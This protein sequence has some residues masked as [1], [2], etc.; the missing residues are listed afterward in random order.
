[1]KYLPI[2]AKLF[3]ENR[4]NF[5]KALPPHSIAFFTSNDEMPRSADGH[6]P[7]RQN[8]DLFYLSGIDQEQ[9]VLLLFPDAPIAAYKEVLFI[10]KTDETIAVW[11][12]HKYTIEEARK[13]SGIET[14]V[15]T[16]HF[17][18]ICDLV[19]HHAISVFLNLNEHD[20]FVT[21]IECRD[22]RFA[23]VLRK[24]HPLH[25][26][27]RAAP[28]MSKLRSIKSEPEIQLIATAIDI[29]KNAFN[30]LLTFIR[31][32]CT[33]Y[34]IEAEIIHEFISKRSSGHAYYPII[35][36]GANACILHY[37]QNNQ[38]CK[39]GDLILMDFGAEYAN[40]AAD[41]TRTVPVNGKFSPRQRQVYEAVLRVLK[42]ARSLLVVG[43]TMEAYNKAVGKIMELELIELGLLDAKA[44]EQHNKDPKALPLYKKY[45]NHG[46]SH[47]LGLDVHDVGNRYEPMQAG[48]V[49]T[50]EPGIY[51]PEENMGIRL[52]NDILITKDGPLDLTTDIPIEVDAIEQMM[53]QSHKK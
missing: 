5:K 26:Y 33:E 1:M 25:R 44:V 41:L 3:N 53:Q 12:G 34:Q 4:Q 29:T 28:L 14:I 23:K 20:R 27:E 46:C 11:E 48:M 7:F 50:C 15:W 47:F 17:D 49:F 32:G 31:P 18:S 13:T 6:F 9:T 8:S 39:A 30:R 19:M 45:F 36:S 22:Q 21:E 10:R 35:A 42:A 37:N 43:Q 38:I 2:D 52:E 40:Y 16:E 24:K 51:I